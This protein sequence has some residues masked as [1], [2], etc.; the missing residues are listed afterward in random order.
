ML[1]V[2]VRT[3]FERVRVSR[4]QPALDLDGFGGG[5]GGGKRLV[6]PAQVRPPDA[7]GSLNTLNLPRRSEA[8][9]EVTTATDRQTQQCLHSDVSINLIWY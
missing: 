1:Q 7:Q 5:G 9:S 4:G 3:G 2:G 8:L 6:P